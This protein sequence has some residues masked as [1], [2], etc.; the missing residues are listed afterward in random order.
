LFSHFSPSPEALCSIQGTS[1]RVWIIIG[2]ALPREN[3]NLGW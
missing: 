2:V 1:V 3:K